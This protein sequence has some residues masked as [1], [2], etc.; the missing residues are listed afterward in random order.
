MGENFRELLENSFSQRKLLRIYGIPVRHTT[1]MQHWKASIGFF[2][3]TMLDNLVPVSP[4]C[5]QPWLSK[6][7]L[8]SIVDHPNLVER[9][10][11]AGNRQTLLVV[12]KICTWELLCRTSQDVTVS[13]TNSRLILQIKLS[14]IAT[15]TQ[16]SWNFSPAKETRYT[17]DKSTFYWQKA[18][19]GLT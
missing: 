10:Q 12:E 5:W 6:W 11:R 9:N 19:D 13:G 8:P 17:V 18:G 2:S 4:P 14:Q 16:N 7:V 3:S 1:L 15:E